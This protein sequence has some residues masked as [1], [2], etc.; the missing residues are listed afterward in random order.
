V[1]WLVDGYN[2]IRRDAELVAAEAESL[3]AGRAALLRLLAA[4]A[5][6]SGEQ[7][8]VVFDGARRGGGGSG[9]GQVRVRFSTPPERADDV[10]M[11]EAARL[12]EG[13]V[14]VTSDRT[15]ADAA[16]RS[17]AVAVSAE[18]FLETATGDSADDEEQP[19]PGGN[20]RRPSRDERAVARVL[21]RLQPR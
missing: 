17:G 20:P 15:V 12:R 21:R 19:R 14:V 5:R 7:F 4:V 2:V 8:V 16:R 18:R 10:L 11:R 9:E 1:L 3:E 6:D 13:A